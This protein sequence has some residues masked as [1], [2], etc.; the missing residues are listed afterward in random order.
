L[1]YLYSNIL[2]VYADKYYPEFYDDFK[3]ESVVLGDAMCPV[4]KASSNMHG[5]KLQVA[6][7]FT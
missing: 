7:C 5:H 1:V 6:F 3:L 4:H 2:A